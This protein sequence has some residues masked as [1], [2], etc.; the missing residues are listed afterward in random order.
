MSREGVHGRGSREGVCL[1][2]KVCVS[3]VRRR[4]DLRMFIHEVNEG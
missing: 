1:L 3:L 2:S 4:V